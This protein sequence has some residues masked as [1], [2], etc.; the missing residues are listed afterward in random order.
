MRLRCLACRPLLPGCLD[1][2]E[3]AE[4]ASGLVTCAHGETGMD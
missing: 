1:I 3:K 4:H 2:Q